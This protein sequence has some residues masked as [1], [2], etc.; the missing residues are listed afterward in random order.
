[1]AAIV[2]TRRALIQR[3]RKQV[4]NDRMT[5]DAFETSDN[6]ICLLIDQEAAATMIAN[7]YMGAKVEGTLVVPEAYYIT[8]MLPALQQDNI[9]KDWYTTLPQ[10]PMSLPLGYSIDRCFFANASQGKS[11]DILPIKNKRSSFINFL[12]R[13][14]GAQYEI[15]GGGSNIRITAT[16]GSSLTGQQ[17]YVR[18]MSTRTTN[19][20]AVMN[21]PEDDVSAIF[22]SVIKLLMMRYG[23]PY[24]QIQDDLPAGNKPK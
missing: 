15:E 17:V 22:S 10:P 20:D 19:L 21:M 2:W 7:I 3:I 13:P 8:Y 4:T 18:M 11:K 5:N 9:M 14:K 24:D 6:E 12:P 23:V 16:D 1:M